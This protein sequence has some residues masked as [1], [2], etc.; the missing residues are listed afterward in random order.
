MLIWINGAF[1]AGKSHTAFELR[2]RLAEAHLADP[3]LLGSA[4]H[5][6]LPQAMRGDFQDLP[7]W[8]SVVVETLHQAA[9]SHAGP[10]LVPMTIVNDDYFDEIVGGLRERGV[11]VRHYTLVASP[12][13]LR[14]RLGTRLGFIR[15]GG[16]RET[17]AMRQIPRCVEQ[18]AQDRY[19]THV[20]TDDRPLD[21]IVEWI[22][23]DAGLD[24]V[25]PR[26]SPVRFQMRRLQ[27]A[28][29][30]IR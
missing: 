24:L 22:A 10:L 27:V 7:L 14:R 29:Q 12:A 19:G 2:R 28:A 15:S 30:L 21:E 25:G 18:L 6:M 13:T 26:L 1:G 3:E 20:R 17:W 5:R 4:L 9:A 16:R 11:D 23:A 8:R